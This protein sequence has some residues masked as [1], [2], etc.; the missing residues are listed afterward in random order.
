MCG[1]L[2]N[3]SSHWLYPFVFTLAVQGNSPAPHLELCQ[4]EENE[5]K[6]KLNKKGP[7]FRLNLSLTDT[8]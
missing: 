2:R 4:D 7:Q 3:S 6:E 5:S 8:D 1:V